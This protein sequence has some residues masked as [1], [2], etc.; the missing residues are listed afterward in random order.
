MCVQCKN[1][2]Q[3]KDNFAGL[4]LSDTE[5][6]SGNL[7]D[8]QNPL[9]SIIIP[10]YKR[11]EYLHEA[12][13]SAIDQRNIDFVYEIIVVCDDP[14]T[15]LPQINEY[16]QIKNL[17]FYR[18]RRNLGLYNNSNLA[19]KIARGRYISFLHDDD[20][21][22]PDYLSETEKFLLSEKDACCVLANRD[23]TFTSFSIKRHIKR[24][25]L[26]PSLAIR[27]IFSKRYKLITL[28]EGL[29]YLLS[30]V[31][32]APSCGAL[33]EKEAFLKSGGFNQDFWPVSDYYFF[34]KF[35][36]SHPVYMSRKKLAC[37]RWFDNLSQN[38][39]IQLSGFEHLADFFQSVQ[40]ID[41]VNRYYKYFH[42]EILYSK[43][44]MINR[45]YRN[46]IVDKFPELKRRNA[47]KWAFFKCYNIAFS[48]FH[49]L[50]L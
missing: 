12:I 17:Y 34:L 44:L 5:L 50:V 26:L 48:F 42:T 21:L 3:Y 25:V 24:F 22:Y 10:V 9:V 15:Q 40:P 27:R 6:L 31:Y 20:I 32:K 45:E 11:L 19:A 8:T 23:T 1:I 37:Y 2:Y 16:R 49:N 18:N 39:T 38:K 29:T 36:L 14:G 33:F 4:E 28:R 47:I 46:E 7:E 30:N 13:N 43:F 35:N 41:A